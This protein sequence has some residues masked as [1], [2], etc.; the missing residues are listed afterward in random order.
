M[1]YRVAKKVWASAVLDSRDRR[2]SSLDTSHCSQFYC[3]CR[4]SHDSSFYFSLSGI[5]LR[6]AIL[7]DC[8]HS[9][10]GVSRT[11]HSRN[12][13]RHSRDA[14]AD[15]IVRVLCEQ[16]LDYV[17]RDVAFK[18]VAIDLDDVTALEPRRH[19]RLDAHLS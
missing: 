7:L 13:A 11:F 4:C 19:S 14:Q 2:L 6:S 15:D 16:P 10:R 3:S 8:V 1:K 5:R 9:Q 18:H 12:T 17:A